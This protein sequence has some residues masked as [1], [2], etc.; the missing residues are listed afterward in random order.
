[1]PMKNNVK[2]LLLLFYWKRTLLAFS[3]AEMMVVMLILSI[4]M[5]ASMPIITKRSKV[6]YESSSIPAGVIVVWYGSEASIPTGWHLCDGGTY[7]GYKTPDLRSRFV[8]GAGGDV[9]TK[10]SFVEGWDTVANG[11][12]NI[13]YTGGEEQH[14]LL[15]PE[16]PQHSHTASTTSQGTH[17]HSVSTSPAG[18]HHHLYYYDLFHS[19]GGASSLASNQGISQYASLPTND[20]GDHS[21]TVTIPS[22]GSHSH[23]ITVNNAGSGET[24]NI[25][26]RFYTLAYIM[27]V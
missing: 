5:A 14:R 17:T 9:N 21:H 3:L 19:V 11:H 16:M 20:V 7:N 22:S 23:T 24:H 2:N 10:A 8:Y 12:L 13:N 27:K 4:V 15:I 26:P 6:H 18:G 1:M 25:M